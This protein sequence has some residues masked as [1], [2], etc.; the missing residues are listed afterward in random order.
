MITVTFETN[1]K[2]LGF[3]LNPKHLINISLEDKQLTI[4][5]TNDVRLLMR[6]DTHEVAVR[7]FKGLSKE[8]EKF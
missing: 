1:S 3:I 7:I 2:E 5:F 8:L 4:T 6:P